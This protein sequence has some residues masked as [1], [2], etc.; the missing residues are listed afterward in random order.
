MLMGVLMKHLLVVFILF[1]LQRCCFS[2]FCEDKLTSK[3]TQSKS[4]SFIENKLVRA[5][6]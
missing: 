3:F 2:F 6:A 5:S 1:Y 4:F